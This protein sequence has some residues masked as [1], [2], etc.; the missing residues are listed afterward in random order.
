[1][2]T[3]SLVLGLLLLAA[4]PADAAPAG[5]IAVV[6]DKGVAPYRALLDGFR[7]ASA[8][9]VR[10]VAPEDAREPGFEERLQGR[11]A[12]RFSRSACRRATAVEGLRRLPVLLAMAPQAASWVA[13][14]PNRL[15]IEMALSPRQHLET[16]RRVF[17][18]AQA[19][20]ASS[21]TPGRPAGYVARGRG[22]RGGLGLTLVTR[23]IAR[24]ADLSRRLEELRGQIDVLWLLPDPTVLQGENLDLLLLASFESRLPLYGFA[25]KYVELGAVAAAHLD[26]A[27]MGAQAAGML[28]ACARR[29][30]PRPRGPRWQYATGARLVVNQKVARK[31]GIDLDPALLEAR[32]RCPSLGRPDASATGSSWSSRWR[33]LAISASFTMYFVHIREAAAGSALVD[34][35]RGL[36]GLLATGARIAV[37]S[38]NA[39]LVQE[40]LS[41]VVERRDTLAAAVFSLDGEL[42]AP[43]AAA[44]R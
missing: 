29:R 21:S 17:P 32:R 11:G 12:A 37:Y 1:M 36:G 8:H 10:V 25:R 14:Q 40:T 16:L 7:E 31:M 2:K 18:R 33:W 39:Q 9:P 35:S 38:E 5:E 13:A 15:G 19:R 24:P 20:S 41:G 42:V 26:P 6:C 30:P 4:A 44:P 28:A 3:P 27:A 22:R 43:R 23:E 34:R